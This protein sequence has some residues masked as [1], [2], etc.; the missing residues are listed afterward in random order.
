MYQRM[1]GRFELWEPPF[2]DNNEKYAEEI[3]RAKVL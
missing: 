1:I 2:S 3:P